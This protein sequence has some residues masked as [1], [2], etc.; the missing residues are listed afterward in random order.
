MKTIL[1]LTDFT[2][3]S[4]HA[5]KCSVMLG[6]KLHADL[7]LFNTYITAPVI[8]EYA[9][10][11][12]V[13]DEIMQ[14]EKLCKNKLQYLHSVLEDTIERLEPGASKPAV[15]IQ[16]GEGRL[17][18][19]VEEIIQ[20]KDIELVVMGARSGS[21][22]EHLLTGSETSEVINR[23]ARPVFILP[24]NVNLKRIKKV[25]FATDFDRADMNAV[26][27]LIKIGKEFNFQLG[28]VHIAIYGDNTSL[29]VAKEKEFLNQVSKL[30][31]PG[32]TYTVVRGKDVINRLNKL[33]DE[34]GA[35]MLALVH[36]QHSFFMRL[37]Q[38]STTGEALLNQSIPLLAIPSKMEDE[39]SLG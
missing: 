12:W 7:L 15:H 28:I 24:H 4:A 39:N 11:P 6:S 26:R 36:H 38:Q 5:A 22:I 32:I 9:G 13:A 2:E 23:S 33:C 27:Y 20:Q 21:T 10:G 31:Y 3:N 29:K 18:I 19:N 16:S 17:G 34:T 25:V 30:D 37:F 1:I 8:P 14:R 35:D